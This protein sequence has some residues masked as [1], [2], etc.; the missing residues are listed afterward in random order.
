[1]QHRGFPEKYNYV[2]VLPTITHM[3]QDHK[4]VDKE[5]QFALEE[6]PQRFPPSTLQFVAL[7]F[8]CHKA[9]CRIQVLGGEG[10][11]MYQVGALGANAGGVLS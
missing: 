4:V 2:Y 6:I 7:L 11:G 9:G 3:F 5:V 1:V 10:H 8:A